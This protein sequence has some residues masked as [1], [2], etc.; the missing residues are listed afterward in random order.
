MERHP[1]Y[2]KPFILMMFDPDEGTRKEQEV[3]RE[4]WTD[5]LAAVEGTPNWL[6]SDYA[7]FQSAVSERR[8]KYDELVSIDSPGRRFT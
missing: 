3:H 1:D 6:R 8:Y 5:G 4:V 2:G 7:A